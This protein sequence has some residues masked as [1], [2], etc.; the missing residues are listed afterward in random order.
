MSDFE[1]AVWV[2][3]KKLL[4]QAEVKGCGF[5]LNQAM[6]KNMKKKRL[7]PIYNS[8]KATRTICR[9]IIIMIKK[10]YLFFRKLMS[11]NLLPAEKISKRFYLIRGNQ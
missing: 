9:L 10:N 7:G 4:S 5:L 3:L 8:D 2:T 6:F 1:A 11:L